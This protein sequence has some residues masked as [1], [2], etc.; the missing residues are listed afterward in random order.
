[1]SVPSTAKVRQECQE[2]G[3]KLLHLLLLDTVTSSTK[4]YINLKIQ[5]SSIIRL[6]R[7][8]ANVINWFVKSVI[9]LWRCRWSLHCTW[10]AW[11]GTLSMPLPVSSREC[12]LVC[13]I[14]D[15]YSICSQH[16]EVLLRRWGVLLAM[17]IN[18][19]LWWKAP[20]LFLW[21]HVLAVK[22]DYEHHEEHTALLSYAWRQYGRASLKF[23]SV[24]GWLWQFSWRY[25]GVPITIDE[26]TSSPLIIALVTV[27]FLIWLLARPQQVSYR[28]DN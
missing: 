11:E 12:S 19:L 20:L 2:K 1:M 9:L 6:F 18:R 8:Y 17:K 7:L 5:I 10:R 23:L 3:C 24:A 25:L 22:L 28:F 4:M 13:F 26:G 16:A 27:F 21:F 15:C 14:W